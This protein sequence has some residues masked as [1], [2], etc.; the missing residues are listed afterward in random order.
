MYFMFLNIL[1][2]NNVVNFGSQ[3]SNCSKLVNI[4]RFY[5]YCSQPVDGCKKKL[6]LEG[7]Y[8]RYPGD[9]NYIYIFILTL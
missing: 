4:P 1:N 7:I 2:K 5:V 9:V 6:C 3:I 8:L